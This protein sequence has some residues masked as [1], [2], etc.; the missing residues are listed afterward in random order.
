VTHDEH[1]EKVARAIWNASPTGIDDD[2]D[3]DA[4]S[5]GARDEVREQAEAAIEAIEPL[6]AEAIVFAC[7]DQWWGDATPEHVA[8]YRNE[9]HVIATDDYEPGWGES[10]D[11]FAARVSRAVI[12]SGEAE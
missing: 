3:W 6:I 10:L 4:L 9:L 12:D 5:T 8:K 2:L 11:D 1:V 7:V